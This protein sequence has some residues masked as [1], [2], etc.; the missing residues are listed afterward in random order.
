MRNVIA[1][2]CQTAAVV[3]A[4]LGL[5]FLSPLLVAAVVVGSV[6]WFLAPERRA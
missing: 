2:V 5:W 1:T 4:V 3:C 6:G